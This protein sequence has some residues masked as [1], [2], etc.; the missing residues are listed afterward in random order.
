[1]CNRRV[2]VDM[3]VKMSP[4]HEGPPA[5]RG[6]FGSEPAVSLRGRY[7][8]SC[9]LFVGQSRWSGCREWPPQVPDATV[10]PR[11]ET[12]AQEQSGDVKDARR[13]VA[14]TRDPAHQVGRDWLRQPV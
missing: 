1:M 9:F 13:S 3:C 10:S 7:Y 12:S 4:C 6:H 8:C 14:G 5:T 2:P 11:H